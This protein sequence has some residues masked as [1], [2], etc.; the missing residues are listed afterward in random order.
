VAAGPAYG[1]RTDAVANHARILDAARAVLAER[2][3][4]LEVNE[5]ADRAG[6][7]VGTLYRH[8][9]N[10]DDLVR[11]VLTQTHQD[12]F[13]LIRRAADIEDPAAALRQIPL[14]LTAEPVTSLFSL[15]QDSRCIKL[16]QD[17][18][19]Q[20]SQSMTGEMIELIAGIVERGVRAGVFRADLDPPATAAAILGS[21]GLVVE[22]LGAT[23]PLHELAEL[24]ADLHSSM[25]SVR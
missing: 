24:L 5:V 23:R 22:M 14:F 1:R 21:M 17:L 18:K 19:Q 4:D 15:M 9:A 2:G 10:R 20:M 16:M 13:S 11:A 3:L 6:V 12:A 25:V 8:F 7:G